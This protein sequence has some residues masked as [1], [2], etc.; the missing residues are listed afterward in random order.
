MPELPEVQALANFLA[1]RAVGTAVRGVDVCAFSVLKT[2]A[3]PISELV[4]QKVEQVG[5]A[6]KHL[7]IRCGELRLVI[8]LSRA[9]WLRWIRETP[10]RPPKPG[11]G[12]LALR[13]RC[14]G[15]RESFELTEAGTQKRLAVWVVR[16]EADVPSVA[17]LG[18]DALDLD[19]AGLAGILAGTTARIKNVLVDQH[20]IAG[21]G[22]AYSDEILFAAKISPFSPSDKTDPG[23]LFPALRGVL[24]EA[25]ERAV[26]QEA[27]LLKAE[28][29][30]GMR[31]HGRTGEPCS[32]CGDVV[33]EVS[34]ADRS[35]QYCATCQTGGHVLADRRMSR[36]LK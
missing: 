29:R 20:L 28:K 27:A 18:P 25:V 12:P 8:H 2:A 7:I 15:E 11:R 3:P 26:G 9:G 4:G 19:E 1:D 33:R 22:N 21:I 31:V 23:Q 34:F 36:L 5:R 14:G 30:E 10:E 16:D 17:K 13:V 32:A 24:L 35:W 6:G